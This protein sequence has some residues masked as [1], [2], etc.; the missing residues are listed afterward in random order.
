MY[1]M[2]MMLMVLLVILTSDKVSNDEDVIKS[3]SIRI[4]AA[5]SINIII[6]NNR[7]P[8]VFLHDM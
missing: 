6:F 1:Q 8:A 4:V 5:D 3:D 2:M 7:D